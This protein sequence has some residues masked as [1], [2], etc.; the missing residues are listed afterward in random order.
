M[1]GAVMKSIGHSLYEDM[2]LDKSGKCINANLT[3]YGAPM[4]DGPFP[5]LSATV[6]RLPSASPFTMP[7]VCGC[8]ASL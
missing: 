7:A 1:Y 5:R 8:A 2:K 3:D 4:I 6:R